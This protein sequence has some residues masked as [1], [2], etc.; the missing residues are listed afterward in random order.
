M[1]RVGELFERLRGVHVRH[2][3]LRALAEA[4]ARPVRAVGPARVQQR[5]A[6]EQT[7]PRSHTRARGDRRRHRR[8]RARARR[9]RRERRPCIA[10]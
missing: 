9:R 2:E 10:N 3:P 6:V 7:W 5:P 8:R 1:A 4:Q